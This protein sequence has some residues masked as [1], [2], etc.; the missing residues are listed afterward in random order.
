LAAGTLT[1]LRF[2]QV[3]YDEDE[4]I[5]AIYFVE[6]AVVSLVYN[7]DDGRTIEVATVGR[8]GMVGLPVF[9]GSGEIVGQAFVQI[10]GEGIR[11]SARR[12]AELAAPGTPL[13]AVLQKYAQL[14]FTQVVLSAV[15]NRAHDVAQRCARWILMT[16]DGVQRD[17][18][19]LTQEL[20]AQMLG[21]RRAGVSLAAGTLARAG[22]IRYSRGRLVV[23][24]RRGLES[25]ACGCYAAVRDQFDRMLPP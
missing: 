10:P 24:N 9:W 4:Q 2:K 13:H 25:A 14:L 21:V 16:H 6:S 1:P 23:R 7:V 8:E 19:P 20:L 12:F 22:H 3:L 5:E 15:C 17:E 11:L 18:F